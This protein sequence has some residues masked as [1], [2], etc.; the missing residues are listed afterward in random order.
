MG[1]AQLC[2][3]IF[4]DVFQPKHRSPTL[5]E[6]DVKENMAESPEN[7]NRWSHKTTGKI[8]D[9]NQDYNDIT[10]AFKTSQ[11]TALASTTRKN[12]DSVEFEVDRISKCK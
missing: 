2:V 1:T 3:F 5:G 12:R 8:R 9:I 11:P 10:W 7:R 6:G 4:N